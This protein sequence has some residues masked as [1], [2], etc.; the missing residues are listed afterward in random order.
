MFFMNGRGRIGPRLGKQKMATTGYAAGVV[1]LFGA[2]LAG[3]GRALFIGRDDGSVT[4][5]N[6]FYTGSGSWISVASG[7]KGFY[8]TATMTTLPI[9]SGSPADKTVVTDVSVN[10]A[11]TAI[12]SPASALFVVEGALYTYLQFDNGLWQL[13]HTCVVEPG[14]CCGG[15]TVTNTPSPIDCTG[16]I[17]LTGVRCVAEELGETSELSGDV[18]VMG[19][20]V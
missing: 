17:K 4:V 19:V 5:E 8:T 1:S 10:G 9:T 12:A 11:T 16:K 14:G 18:V 7:A 2:E 3:V 6:A 13:A 20:K 15:V